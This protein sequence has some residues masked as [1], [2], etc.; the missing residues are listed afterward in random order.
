M[1]HE[2]IER[3]HLSPATTQPPL[4]VVGV[5]SGGVWLGQKLSDR[6]VEYAKLEIGFSELN[7]SSF[8]D[9]RPRTAVIDAVG[10]DQRLPAE[11]GVVILV[12]D[13]IQSGRTARA[14]LEAI[15][16]TYRPALI[17][18]AVLVDRGHRELPICPDYVGK[19]LP[20]ALSEYVA[21][22]PQGV[23]IHRA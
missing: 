10:V 12:D 11:G 22:T 18:L 16:S 7:I 15:L 21:V 19:N 3:L 14:A 23:T 1:A 13:V 17:Q 6:L 8:R 20:S 9:D 2:I 5:R 4:S